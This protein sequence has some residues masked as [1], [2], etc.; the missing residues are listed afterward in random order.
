[1]HKPSIAVAPATSF[2]MGIDFGRAPNS[3]QSIRIKHEVVGATAMLSV[4][5][6]EDDTRSFIEIG[7]DR[8][9]F[10]NHRNFTNFFLKTMKTTH[11]LNMEK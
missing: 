6:L 10:V 7:N 11:H 2:L 3:P 1:M 8:S 5:L 4:M 9:Y